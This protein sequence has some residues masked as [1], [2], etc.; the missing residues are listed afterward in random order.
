MIEFRN[1]SKQFGNLEVLHDLN[2]KIVEGEV[3]GLLGPNGAGKTTSLRA[4]TG[5]L[6]ASRGSVIVDGK[7]PS[8]DENIKHN[9][10]FLPENN[11]LYEDMTVEEWLKFWSQIKYQLIKV[12][13]IKEAVTK[14][15]LKDVYYRPIM[16][17]SKGYRQRV[18][19]AQAILGQPKILILDEPTEGLDPNQR[20]E[21]H[22][23]IKDLG[24]KRTVI[25]SSHV[26]SEISKMCSRVMILHK[27]IIVADGSP[28]TLGNKSGGSQVIEA[29][30][31]GT[32]VLS[33]LKKIP[34]I[35]EVNE[36][37]ETGPG[38]RFVITCNPDMDL[39]VDVFKTA[40]LQKW[41][42]YELIR[43]QI[44]LEDIFAQ[45]TK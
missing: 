28:E 25:I 26:L 4:M 24:K 36:I 12:E 30:I 37:E 44:A 19:L 29:V 21:I 14:S 6:P 31:E 35:K 23:L 11:P 18:G 20:H 5:L 7:N 10:G 40:A 13:E 15:G 27:G 2:F 39:R 17:L 32:K 3:V 1:V 43:K 42:L 34:G 9:L 22:N 16:E 45:L 8:E 33:I 41:K 38:N